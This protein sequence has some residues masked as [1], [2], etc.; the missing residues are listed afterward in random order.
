MIEVRLA[1]MA[2]ADSST[3]LAAN[4]IAQMS[5]WGFGGRDER[6]GGGQG[7]KSSGTLLVAAS[8][9][10]SRCFLGLVMH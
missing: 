6:P 8:V 3:M 10:L 7:R 4:C 9:S 2:Q 5:L 1:L